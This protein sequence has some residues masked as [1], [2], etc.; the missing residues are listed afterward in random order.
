MPDTPNAMDFVHPAYK[1]R[2]SALLQGGARDHVAEAY[3]HKAQI[4]HWKHLAATTSD[5]RMAEVYKS[6]VPNQIRGIATARRNAQSGRD[7]TYGN[8]IANLSPPASSRQ[9]G[10]PA[11]ALSYEGMEGQRQQEQAHRTASRYRQVARNSRDA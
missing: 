1:E 10:L 8:D 3:M 2:V 7:T 11:A 9:R 5:R 6:Q 4:D